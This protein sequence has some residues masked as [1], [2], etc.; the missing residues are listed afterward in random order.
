MSELAEPSTID[1]LKERLGD[2][3]LEAQDADGEL[4]LEATAQGLR[5]V[6]F[7]LRDE[8]GFDYPADLTAFDTGEEFVV[9]YRLYSMV[10]NKTAIIHVKLT[11]E[12]PAVPSV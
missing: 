11:R 2:C 9:W 12:N 8:L 10:D 5:E 6:C 3:I 7:F 1:I 4:R